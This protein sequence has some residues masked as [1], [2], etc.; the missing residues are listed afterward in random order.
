M[1]R[2]RIVLDAALREKLHDLSEPPELCDESGRVVARL[3]PVYD[4]SEFGPLEPQISEEDLRRRE[5][6]NE[7]RYT[8]AEVLG[9]LGRR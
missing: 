7:R 6:S 9:H 5:Q 2:T 4:P 3:T 1:V 8:T